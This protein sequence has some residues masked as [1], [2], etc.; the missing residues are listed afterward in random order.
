MTT[1]FVGN[2][3]RKQFVIVNV[4]RLVFTCQWYT[5]ALKRSIRNSSVGVLMFVFLEKLLLPKLA[6]VAVAVALA[7]TAAAACIEVVI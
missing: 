6:V 7:T 5:I 3:L 2:P 1:T 4:R